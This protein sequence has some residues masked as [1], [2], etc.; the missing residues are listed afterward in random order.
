M[1]VENLFGLMTTRLA[2]RPMRNLEEVKAE[3][4]RCWKSIIKKEISE[5][6]AEMKERMHEAIE[7]DGI[8]TTNLLLC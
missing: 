8:M 6:F 2:D 4:N 1:I 7:F 3:V 5:A